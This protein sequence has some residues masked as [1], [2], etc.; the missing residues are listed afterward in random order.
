MP[1]HQL[2][3]EIP[4]ALEQGLWIL[5]MKGRPYKG[6]ALDEAHETLIIR[7]LKRLMN[8]PPTGASLGLRTN[9]VNFRVQVNCGR[10]HTI[11]GPAQLA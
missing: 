8:Q 6:Q 11:R 1:L 2:P 5:C 9:Y 4:N 7:D 10:R 3:P